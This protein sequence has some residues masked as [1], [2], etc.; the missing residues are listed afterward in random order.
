MSGKRLGISLFVLDML[1]IVPALYI[2]AYMRSTLPFGIPLSPEAITVPLQVYAITLVS[3]GFSLTLLG[4]Y[5]P[6][7]VLRWYEDATRV[8]AASSIAVILMAGALYFTIRELSRLQFAYS[9]VLIVGALLSYRA[10]L[11]ITYR[12]GGWSRP[13]WGRRILVLGSGELA[14]RVVQVILDHSRWGYQLV[15]LAADGNATEATPPPPIRYLGD[16]SDLRQL[17]SRFQIDEV[18]AAMPLTEYGRLERIVTELED[19][20]VRLEVVPDFTKVALVRARTQT[21]GGLP[22]I[23]LRDPVIVGPPRLV[24]RV[25]DV[26]LSAVLLILL[27]PVMLLIGASIRLGSAGPAL[28][29]QKRLGEN[30]RLFD[31]LKFRTMVDGADQKIEAM[32][33]HDEKG[34]VIHKLPDD[35]RVTPLGRF[36]RGYSLDELPQL[37]NVLKGD[38]SLV[39]P[40]PE[41]PWLVE[42]YQPWQRKRFAVPQGITGWWQ[43]N[44]RSDKPMHLHTEDDLFYVYNYSIWL[45]LWILLRTP[46]AVL[47]GRGAY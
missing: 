28:F 44:G 8:I 34:N 13:G 15:G 36:L 46:F 12:L 1:L 21:I 4:A 31:M 3:W 45:D 20:P 22:L 5:D 42:R 29:A 23:G 41:M 24:K 30:G 33:K 26:V 14:N 25:F 2:A 37:L 38:M 19:L 27:A 39:G 16:T 35:P 18:W 17:V 32:L 11:R 7:R 43:I 10:A 6:K 47:R 40:R 9:F